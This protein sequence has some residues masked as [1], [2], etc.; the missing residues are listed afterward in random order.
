MPALSNNQAFDQVLMTQKDRGV[1]LLES[2]SISDDAF[3]EWYLET[4]SI[5]KRIFGSDSEQLERFDLAVGMGATEESSRSQ[6]EKRIRDGLRVVDRLLREIKE[7]RSPQTV[8]ATPSDRVFLVHGRDSSKHEV[9]RFLERAKLKLVILEEEPNRGQTIIEKFETHATNVAYA[10][11]LLTPDDEG[12]L[13]GVSTD[14]RPRARQNVIFEL[15]FFVGRLGRDKVALLYKGPV[16]IPTDF[17]GVAYI[18]FEEEDWQRKLLKE[19]KA[20]ELDVDSNCLLA[21]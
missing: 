14:S 5:V 18:S 16:E 10:V 4:K 20:A 12:Y 7:N 19:L 2:S 3:R 17:S 6:I 15:G 21:Q 8:N 1:S 13:K 11:V 9:A